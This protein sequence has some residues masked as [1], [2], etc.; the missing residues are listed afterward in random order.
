MWVFFFNQIIMK[1]YSDNN[2][3][4]VK[5]W[6]KALRT[7]FDGMRFDYMRKLQDAAISWSVCRCGNLY[8]SIPRTSVGMPRDTELATLGSLFSRYV[9]DMFVAYSN[10]TKWNYVSAQKL[11]IITSDKIEARAQVL[12]NEMN[13]PS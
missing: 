2:P 1:K 11:A 7:P 10:G 6:A 8:N 13:K 9:T 4:Q 3:N 5:D 12:L